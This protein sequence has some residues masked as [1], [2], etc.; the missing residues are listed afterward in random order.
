ML[1]EARGYRLSL[2]L[3]H[4]HLAQLPRALRE[5]VSANARNKIYFA[6]SAEDAHA[7]APALAPEV[8]EHDLA[9]LGRHQAAC[10]L[11]ADGGD[12]PAFTIATRPPEPGRDRHAHSVRRAAR[13]TY[14]RNS[15]SRAERLLHD[16]VG[17]AFPG[18]F[19]EPGGSR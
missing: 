18:R 19:D 8:T 4:Q 7:L 2:V 11:V 10:R 1:A 13:Q 6:A 16:T 9:N 14:G 17:E 12:T 15:Q 3:A 5:A